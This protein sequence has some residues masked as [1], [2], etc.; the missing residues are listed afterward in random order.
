[1]NQATIY[2]NKRLT[3]RR[4]NKNIDN[5]IRNTKGG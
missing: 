3:E 2:G 4:V 5:T 1:M